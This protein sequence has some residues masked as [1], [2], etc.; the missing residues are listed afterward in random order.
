MIT[1]NPPGRRHPEP[2]CPCFPSMKVMTVM[3]VV[4]PHPDPVKPHMSQNTNR[5]EVL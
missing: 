2:L 4:V 3:A 1:N 5:R